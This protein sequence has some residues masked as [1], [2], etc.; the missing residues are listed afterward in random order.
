MWKQFKKLERRVEENEPALRFQILGLKS[1]KDEIEEARLEF[2]SYV[3]NQGQFD[4]MRHD[5]C[6]RLR[7][8][9]VKQNGYVEQE[10][11]TVEEE[12]CMKFLEKGN[13]KWG[14]EKMAESLMIHEAK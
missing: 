5:C 14:H 8:A 6:Q 3:V 4:L 10:G 13:Q 2:K 11:L 7:R 12:R 9:I 1:A